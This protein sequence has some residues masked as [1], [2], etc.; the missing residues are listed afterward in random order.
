MMVSILMPAY[1]AQKYVQKAVRSILEQSHRQIELLICD[2]YST[3]NTLNIVKKI[4]DDRVTVYNNQLNLGYLKTCNFLFEKA[5]GD[6]I[7]FQDADDWSHPER[8]DKQLNEFK[9]NPSLGI[10]GTFAYYYDKTGINLIKEKRI[11]VSNASIKE[12]ILTE[13]QF[14]G[15]SIMIRKKV[16]DEIGPYSLYYDRIGNEDYE[17]SARIV[18]RFE[19]KNIPEFL[20]FVRQSPRSVSRRIRSEK[21]L[22]SDGITQEVIKLRRTQNIDL[23]DVQN[24]EQLHRLEHELLQSFIEDPS[25]RYIKAADKSWYNRDLVEYHR[26]TIL[27]LFSNPIKFRNWKYWIKSVLRIVVTGVGG[28]IK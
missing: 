22:I 5:K 2:D 8:L 13:N 14:C 28:T 1:N 21:Q 10:C 23:L 19:A 27:A 9:K 6:F 3:D 7:S 16:L 17:W 25:S 18:E 4:H 24:K 20:Y 26:N 12:G 15:A 11:Q